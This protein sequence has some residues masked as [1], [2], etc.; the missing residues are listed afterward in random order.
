[1][2]LAKDNCSYLQHYSE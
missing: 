1:M 2:T